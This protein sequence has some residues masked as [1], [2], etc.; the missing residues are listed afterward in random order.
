[1]IEIV[2]GAAERT[3]ITGDNR[4]ADRGQWLAFVL[5]LTGLVGAIGVI[6]RGYGAEGSVIFGATLVALVGTFY[7]RP[8][9]APA[10]AGTEGPVACSRVSEME[11]TVGSLGVR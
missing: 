7:L 6:L 9:D 8:P 5:G 11:S 1:M 4:R 2:P 3:V 10:G